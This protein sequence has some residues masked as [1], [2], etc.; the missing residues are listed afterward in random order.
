MSYKKSKLFLLL[1]P[2]LVLF[3]TAACAIP[4][5]TAPIEVK[6]TSEPP[7]VSTQDPSPFQN[8]GCTWQ[9]NDFAMC[10][11][12]SIPKKM[13]CDTLSKPSDY[14]SL[15]S[16][17][18]MFVLCGY[19]PHMAEESQDPE[20]KGLWDSGCSLQVKQ[21]LFSY[22]NGD[23]LL[24]RDQEDLKYNFAPITTA[25]QALGFAIA[26]SGFSARFDLE[27]LDGY[28]ILADQ[29]QETNVQVVSDGFEIILYR[30]QACGCGPHTTY[31][32][33]VKVTNSGDFQV[34]KS[35]PAFENPDED[36]LCVD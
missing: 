19:Y 12:D 26:T 29:L 14:L 35:I 32:Q 17:E 27:N 2:I 22:L 28:R 6:I 34:L 33:K 23:Y 5:F 30:Y 25:E 8:I 20:P 21:R 9:T 13:G 10:D 24:I 11:Q 4:W 18:R 31:M 36:S 16:P 15:L 3:I 7:V 1:I